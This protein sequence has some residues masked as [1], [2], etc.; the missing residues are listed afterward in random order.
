MS[1]N[2]F[3]IPAVIV[4]FLWLVFYV[5]YIVSPLIVFLV[6][7]FGNLKG[8]IIFISITSIFAPPLGAF[9]IRRGRK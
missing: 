9:L 3:L 2:I 5:K 1:N 8:A 6:N 7:K 4:Y